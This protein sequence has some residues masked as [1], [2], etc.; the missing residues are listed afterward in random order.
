[1][2][3]IPQ[4]V[5]TSLRSANRTCSLQDEMADVLIL[6]GVNQ[7]SFDTEVTQW[8]SDDLTRALKLVAMRTV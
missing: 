7:L 3:T 4:Y 6:V 8:F 2:S 5:Y 1:M